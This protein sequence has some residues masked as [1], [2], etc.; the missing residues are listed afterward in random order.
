MTGEPR[1]STARSVHA[2][3][4][5]H[6]CERHIGDCLRSLWG[7]LG[8]RGSTITVVDNASSDGTPSRV[9]REFPRAEILEP[10]VNL[11]FARGAN[12]GAAR[13]GPGTRWVLLL[14]PDVRLDP[15]SLRSLVTIAELIP[16][17][18]IYGGQPRNERGAPQRA[19]LAAPSLRQALAWATR[20][21]RVRP[22]RRLDPDETRAEG[23]APLSPVAV[24]VGSM[25]LIETRLWE[26]LSGFDETFVQYGEDVD[27]CLRARDLG[28]SPLLCAESRYVHVGGTSVTPTE[29]AI[30]VLRGK[31]E[32]YRRCL[33]PVRAAAAVHVLRAGVAMRAMF[34]STG[35]TEWDVVWSWRE[36][37]TGGFSGDSEPRFRLT[38]VTPPVV[39][40]GDAALAH[41]VPGQRGGGLAHDVGCGRGAG[42]PPR[43]FGAPDGS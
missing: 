2:V 24:L 25:L 30:L 27:L 5:T 19:S 13:R 17:A 14:N 28:A 22:L 31:A 36:K 33:P 37:W 34:A 8:D 32:L 42:Q 43:G 41:G 3:I 4:V 6:N 38:P 39:G 10:G 1:V 9:R 40:S 21:R 29:R 23:R 20:I 16:A 18:G 35:A 26:R 7:D 12:L 15:G 11:G